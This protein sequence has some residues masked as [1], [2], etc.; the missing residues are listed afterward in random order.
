M[1]AL[2]FVKADYESRYGVIKVE[3]R[4]DEDGVHISFEVP[5]GTTATLRLP[6]GVIVAHK[7]RRASTY[8]EEYEVVLNEGAYTFD[9]SAK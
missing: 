8:D 4:R 6:A 7:S 2:N 9:W 1:K 5:A 3:W